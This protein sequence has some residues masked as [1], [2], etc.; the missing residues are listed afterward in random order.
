MLDDLELWRLWWHDQM[1]AQAG[2]ADGYLM[3]ITGRPAALP[4][5]DVAGAARILGHLGDIDEKIR[6]N[7]NLRL[8]LTVLVLR[9]PHLPDTRGS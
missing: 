3:P 8:A 1:L 2:A 6:R 5:L 4:G 7:A 9:L